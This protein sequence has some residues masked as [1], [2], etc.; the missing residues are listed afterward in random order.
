MVFH[1]ACCE[2]TF[3]ALKHCCFPWQFNTK[4]VLKFHFHCLHGVAGLRSVMKPDRCHQPLLDGRRTLINSHVSNSTAHCK[5]IARLPIPTNPRLPTPVTCHS[6]GT[7]VAGTQILAKCRGGT[8]TSRPSCILVI[9]N[10]N[11]YNR[12]QKTYPYRR[13]R[14]RQMI[15]V[16]TNPET[17]D[18]I[19]HGCNCKLPQNKQENITH[20]SKSTTACTNT[21]EGYI[22]NHKYLLELSAFLEIIMQYFIGKR[23]NNW[24]ENLLSSFLCAWSQFCLTTVCST[25]GSHLPLYCLNKEF[26]KQ[27]HSG[28]QQITVQ[29]VCLYIEVKR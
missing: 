2:S 19:K 1:T 21:P 26:T 3:F 25:S 28:E 16:Y 9:Q 17:T 24:Y 20:I 7:P 6:I 11:R 5:L 18:H 23:N 14:I 27:Y 15:I 22:T 4:A 13:N 29:Q 12:S 8:P 10:C